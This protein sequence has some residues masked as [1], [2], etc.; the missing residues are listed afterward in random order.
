MHEYR[1]AEAIEK[2]KAGLE[3]ASDDSERCALLNLIGE[4]RI[5][6]GAYKDAEQTFLEMI[7]IA[8]QAGIDESLAAALGNIGLVYATLGEPHKALNSH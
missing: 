5:R 3:L 7:R 8:E 2:F 1:H 6:S 4:S